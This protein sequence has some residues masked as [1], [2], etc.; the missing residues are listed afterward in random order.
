MWRNSRF[1]L[2]FDE[3]WIFRHNS[4][5][6]TKFAFFVIVWQNLRFSATPWWNTRFFKFLF[7]QRLF[8]EIH[9]FAATFLTKFEFY[10]WPF[11]EICIFSWLIDEIQVF[12]RSFV[13][14][15]FFLWSFDV[16]RVFFSDFFM[17]AQFP[18][19][20]VIRSFCDYSTIF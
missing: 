17:K 10:P 1:S 3:I 18:F 19:I 12:S 15:R 2:S 9:I 8:G 7:S 4:I 5:S 14:I 16:I 6:F 20:V 13:K 11:I